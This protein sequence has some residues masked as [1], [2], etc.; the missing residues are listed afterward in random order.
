MKQSTEKRK[1]R[2][3]STKLPILRVGEIVLVIQVRY[4]RH[5]HAS[6]IRQLFALGLKKIDQGVL[7]MLE[8]EEQLSKLVAISDYIVF[9]YPPPAL[10]DRLVRLRGKVR[11]K[12]NEEGEMVVGSNAPRAKRRGKKKKRKRGEEED[13]M[14]G[15]EE[16]SLSDNV[17]V[18]QIFGDKNL[19]CIEDI[20]HHLTSPSSGGGDEEEEENN[21]AVRKFISSTLL[22]FQLQSPLSRFERKILKTK[23][24][25]RQRVGFVEEKNLIA[26]VEMMI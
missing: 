13:E 14:E 17:I 1:L 3:S 21:N 26:L 10:V 20:V 11:R 12:V 16:V 19:V 9:G 18:E 25:K 4:A 22:P 15:M 8:S 6:V 7:V 23:L 2:S 24:P 5:A